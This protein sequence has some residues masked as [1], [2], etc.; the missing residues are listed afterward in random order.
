MAPDE[1]WELRDTDQEMVDD[2]S[3]DDPDDEDYADMSN[4]AGSKRGGR[5]HS[6]K[7]IRRTKD[8]AR[9]DVDGPSTYPLDVSYHA[10]AVASSSRTQE[11]EEMPIHGYFTLK[12]IESKVIYCLTFSQELPPHPQ[13]RGQK[14]DRTTDFDKPQLAAPVADPNP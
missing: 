12:T 10:T 3:P 14:Q 5:P 9:N 8:R 7:R 11:S 13:D 1:E 2:R 6:R 4:A